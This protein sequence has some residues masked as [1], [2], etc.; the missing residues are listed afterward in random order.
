MDMT[1]DNTQ[2]FDLFWTQHADERL[3]GAE[4][5]DTIRDP[6]S[7]ELVSLPNFIVHGQ[8]SDE[9]DLQVGPMLGQGGMGIV[10]LAHQDSL[11]R[12]VAVKQI[13]KDAPGSADQALVHEARI[14][15]ALEH[16]NIIPVHALGIDENGATTLVMKRV[17]GTNWGELIGDS[18]H[19]GWSSEVVRPADP[20]ERHVGILLEVCKGLQFAHGRSIIHRDL[21]PDNIMIGP[22]G[23]VYILDWGLACRLDM[24][25]KRFRI[26]GTPAY[27]A[28]EML[29]PK[30]K[31]TVRTDIYLLGSCLYEALTGHP[32]HTGATIRDIL[33]SAFGSLPPHLSRHQPAEL[34]R[35]CTT[36]MATNPED[37]YP[38]VAAMRMDLL[39]FLQ[40]RGSSRMA[41]SA[42]QRVDE[43]ER[44]WERDPADEQAQALAAEALFG[45][46]Q[47]REEWPENPAAI[48]GLRRLFLCRCT[49]RLKLDDLAGAQEDLAALQSI[50]THEPSPEFHELS[51]LLTSRI[52][53]RKESDPT[54]SRKQRVV[55][56]LF[57]LVF[58]LLASGLQMQ[59][60]IGNLVDFDAAWLFQ[61]A[62]VHNVV[63]GGVLL[64]ARKRLLN[65]R[66]NRQ[67]AA[68]EV[69]TAGAVLANRGF[70]CLMGTSVGAIF[71][72]D[73]LIL[74]LCVALCGAFLRRSIALWVFPI[75]LSAGLTAVFPH[76]GGEFFTLAV[77]LCGLLLPVTMWKPMVPLK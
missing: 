28:P 39:A 26:V 10:Y 60:V 76:Y 58:I 20:I 33:R 12:E 2:T 34:V 45:L 47:A 29:D 77:L 72:S 56:I 63:Q 7:S 3:E 53:A 24:P 41:E 44:V 52:Q 1:D 17:E 69:A 19:P 65:T 36:A 59:S 14:M 74:A 37:R 51:A 46:R 75:L 55:F 66:F 42:L 11:D 27:L 23:E 31:R 13:R 9:N 4:A 70:G 18:D 16:P 64:L 57:C 67:I 32:P 35:I 54:V 49:R 73:L 8:N 68:I 71:M 22:F 21:K 15:G 30:A 50:E 25:I 6:I 61:L 62:L 43:M 48:E 5:S 38:S 40:H